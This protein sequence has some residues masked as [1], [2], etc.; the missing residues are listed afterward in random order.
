MGAQLIATAA[1][2]FAILTSFFYG[3]GMTIFFG[4]R[5]SRGTTRVDAL[6]AQLDGV[7]SALGLAQATAVEAIMNVTALIPVVT[8]LE[9]GTYTM[10][11]DGGDEVSGAVWRLERVLLASAINFTVLVLDSPTVSCTWPTFGAS[12]QYMFFMY[13]FEPSPFAPY[14]RIGGE[15]IHEFSAENKARIQVST[16]C[17]ATG[18]C[19]LKP[20]FT[21]TII[22][23]SALDISSIITVTSPSGPGESASVYFSEPLQ[24]I[25]PLL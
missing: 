9:N 3:S 21:R 11:C 10:A 2:V 19:A 22:V 8:V 13:A 23:S 12:S 15:V 14:G 5:V 6:H 25:L 16:G 20:Y 17:I 18:A 7:A 4:A 1:L 24:I